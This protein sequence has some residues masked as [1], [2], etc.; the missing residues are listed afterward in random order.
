MR[1]YTDKA[2]AGDVA[3]ARA[4]SKTMDPARRIADK[5][6]NGKWSAPS[7]PISAIMIRRLRCLAVGL[8]IMEAKVP[9]GSD[10][11]GPWCRH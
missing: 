3:G 5:W 11:C 2:R 7:V 8:L 4:A 9:P 1:E 6:M 10:S